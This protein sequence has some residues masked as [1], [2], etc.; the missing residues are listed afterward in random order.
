MSTRSIYTVLFAMT[1]VLIFAG[2]V[3]AAERTGK[4]TAV[5]DNMVTIHFDLEPMPSAG[6]IVALAYREGD[7]MIQIGKWRV[8]AVSGKGTVEATP[9]EKVAA[10]GPPRP[11]MEATIVERIEPPTVYDPLGPLGEDTGVAEANADADGYDPLGPPH[12]GCDAWIAG[13]SGGTKAEGVGVSPVPASEELFQSGLNYRLGRGV[14]KDLPRALQLFVEAA[15]LG[16]AEAAEMAGTAYELGLGTAPDDRKAVALYRQAAVA[17]RPLAQNNLGAFFATGRGGLPRDNAQSVT[18]YLE[19][20]ARGNGWAQANLCVRYETGDGVE[21]N[22][23]EALR[24]C[25]L[26][27]AQDN[28]MGLNQ[29]GWMYQRGSG[30]DKDLTQAFQLYQHSAEL[31]FVNGQN[32]LGYV[33]EHGWGVTRDLQKALYWYR[34]AAAQGFVFAQWNLGRM[35][36]EGLGVPRDEAAAIEFYRQAA[37]AGHG[38]ARKLLEKK[39][40]RWD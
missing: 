22:L 32:N 3:L 7:H 23:D 38:E 10:T 9:W 35:Y 12:I 31:G 36:E 30:V 24:L 14:T 15:G 26:A 27:A 4:V 1:A 25:R 11:G 29:L 2:A 13:S 39:G 40:L 34:Q 18:W 5:R 16:H 28:P 21:K 33:Y 20:A 8:A 19:A 6:D 37:R 17:G